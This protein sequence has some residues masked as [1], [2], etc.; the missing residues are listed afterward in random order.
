[1]DTWG[2]LPKSQTDSETIEQAITR[3]I[4]EHNDDPTAHVSPG[5]SLDNHRLSDVIDHLAGSILADKITPRQL[6]FEYNLN[7]IDD[8]SGDKTRWFLSSPGIQVSTPSGNTSYFDLYTSPYDAFDIFDWSKNPYFEALVYVNPQ[9]NR[10]R[11]FNWGGAIGDNVLGFR[12]ESNKLYAECVINGTSHSSEIVG[13]V[14]SGL[15]NYRAYVDPAT[16]HVKY[17]IDGVLVKELSGLTLSGHDA[18]GLWLRA[19]GLSSGVDSWGVF[20]IVIARDL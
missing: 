13:A 15:K 3:L 19:K 5:Q 2:M 7:T 6:W 20:N 10:V 17:E 16:S 14:V 8:W 12:Y 4:S 9:N 11:I 1:M 18:S